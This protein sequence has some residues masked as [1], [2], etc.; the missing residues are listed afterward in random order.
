MNEP[1]IVFVVLDAFRKD[2]L[3]ETETLAGLTNSGLSFSHAI[4]PATWSLPA[5]A[6]LVSGEP[7]TEHCTYDRKSH[8]F[9]R[10]PLVEQ[11]ADQG[12]DTFGVSANVF[13]SEYYQFDAPFDEFVYTNGVDR[14]SIRGID[15]RR[16]LDESGSLSFGVAT[17]L[18]QAVTSDEMVASLLNVG[19]TLVG[20][21]VERVPSFRQVPHR[22]FRKAG[23]LGNSYRP[24]NN[25]HRLESHIEEMATGEDPFFLFANYMDTHHPYAPPPE[26]RTEILDRSLDARY[27]SNLN[28][29]IGRPWSFQRRLRGEGD[30]HQET[31]LLRHL[32]RGEVRSVDRHL[33]RIVSSL[34]DHD[35]RED[36][37]IVVTA[38]HGENLGSQDRRG[39]RQFGHE[40]TVSDPVVRVPL[41][42]HHPDFSDITIKNR[43]STR[44]LFE[45]LTTHLNRLIDQPESVVRMIFESSADPVFSSS[46][47]TNAIERFDEYST[48][49]HDVIARAV[50]QHEVAG[51][52]NNWK[53]VVSSEGDRWAWKGE[54]PRDPEAVPRELRQEAWS[55]IATLNLAQRTGDG[56]NPPGDVEAELE[57]L[58][59][60]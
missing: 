13:A 55:R 14:E 35:L 39:F 56:G 9:D 58:G 46:P 33:K 19:R 12:Y 4:T 8:A 17:M 27:I 42:I 36:T 23:R 28:E 32:Y 22:W 43:V 38:D 41:V 25:T 21:A 16:T 59:Y 40:A 54:K 48:L 51:F 6:S 15:A 11:L 29:R 18:R 50:E 34:E 44:H 3:S 7:V 49:P 1:N 47:A 24:E 57:A 26:I 37:V 10:V 52:L 60:L 31:E 5:H 30:V 45:L 2:F 53:F 20:T